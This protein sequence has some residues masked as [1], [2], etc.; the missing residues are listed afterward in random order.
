MK[1]K[2]AGFTL[3]ELVVVITIL[4]ILAAFALPRFA[5]L[6]TQARLAS[7][8]GL[9]GSL[10][11]AAALA[12]SQWLAEGSSSALT[13]TMEG[14]TINLTANGYP[15]DTDIANTLQ[16][17]SGYTVTNGLFELRANCSVL[18]DDDGGPSSVS[19]SITRTVTGC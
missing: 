5:N 3:I 1:T 15:Q 8:D 2:Q 9:A 11:A 7:L 16:D 19:P 13:V 18:Y 12:R 14:V 10:R 6:E 4:G 17:T